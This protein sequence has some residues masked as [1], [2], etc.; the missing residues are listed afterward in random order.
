MPKTL[1]LQGGL[2]AL[3]VIVLFQHVE[4]R[5]ALDA[6]AAFLATLFKGLFENGHL[7]CRIQC[8]LTKRQGTLL[9]LYLLFAE[10]P[11]LVLPFHLLLVDGAQEFGI[12][13]YENG[14]AHLQHRPLFC[15]NAFHESALQRVEPNGLDGLHQTFH[16]HIFPERGFHRLDDAMRLGIDLELSRTYRKEDG[17]AGTDDEDCTSQYMKQVPDIPGAGFE[18]NVHL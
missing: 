9:H 6:H 12:A 14:V 15:H 18:L 13:Q 16:I 11:L 8:L 5:L 7:V 10:I 3:I 4:L 1:P 17:I 2:P